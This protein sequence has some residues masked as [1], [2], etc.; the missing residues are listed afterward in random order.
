SPLSSEEHD[1]L[2]KKINDGMKKAIDSFLQIDGMQD[3]FGGDNDS[4][5][6]P[7]QQ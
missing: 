2:E 1:N 3:P 4:G 5:Y 6:I 7:N